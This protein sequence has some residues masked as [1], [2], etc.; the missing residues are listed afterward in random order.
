MLLPDLS[1]LTIDSKNSVD[2]NTE[3]LKA[4]SR[5]GSG[6]LPSFKSWSSLRGRDKWQLMH[7]VASEADVD[8]DDDKDDDGG[9]DAGDD[10][11][12]YLTPY[13]ELDIDIVMKEGQWSVEHVVP[14]SHVL[15]EASNAKSDPLGWMTAT[16]S[17]N[18]RRSNL[19]LVLWN[20]EDQFRDRKLFIIPN[21]R[22]RLDREW[23]YAAP[24][25]QRARLARKWLYIRA[26][27]A[28][29]LRPPSR[30][31]IEN[32]AEIIALAKNFP[33]Y[34]AEMRTNEIY[35]DILDWSN[36]LLSED[37]NRWYDD[38]AWRHRVFS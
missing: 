17:A 32:S 34:P 11:Q 18:S 23:H 36:P 9:D 27:Y 22:I 20:V 1:A 28:D 14:R 5:D 3:W 37:A 7:A 38:A 30:A 24:L 2:T 15:N 33:V 26:T 16:R 25:Q 10:D 21:S 13:D 12:S 4:C 8:K 31:Q 6:Q 19:P 29:D 35:K